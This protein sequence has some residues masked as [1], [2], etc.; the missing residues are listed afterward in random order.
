MSLQICFI[1]LSM[2]ILSGCSSKSTTSPEKLLS[3]DTIL[4]PAVTYRTGNKDKIENIA[5][6]QSEL[7]TLF[8]Q[9]DKSQLSKIDFLRH[10]A[11]YI[12]AGEKPSTGYTVRVTKIVEHEKTI[13]I[14][15]D[16]ASPNSTCP[17][18]GVLTYPF[19]LISIEKTD[20][21]IV[22]ALN[23]KTYCPEI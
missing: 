14:H 18:D 12:S 15:Y 23:P 13:T 16:V 17:T 5:K 4:C 8:S 3:F 11:I 1:F 2:A 6:T 10:W 21:N 20:K 19:C 7:F 9:S 22:F